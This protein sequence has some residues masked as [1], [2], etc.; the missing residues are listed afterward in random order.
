MDKLVSGGWVRHADGALELQVPRAQLLKQAAAQVLLTPLVAASVGFLLADGVDELGVLLAV[1]GLLAT[2]GVA[3]GALGIA[4]SGGVSAAS[5]VVLD[6][7]AGEVRHPEGRVATA[8]VR[9][10][11]VRQGSALTKWLVLEARLGPTA[12][13][14]AGPYAPP[15]TRS[16]VLLGKVPP[17]LGP[18]LAALARDLGAKLGIE[19]RAEGGVDRA[20]PLG[21]TPGTVAMLCYLPV[22]GIFLVASIGVLVVARDPILRFHARQS[23]VL[24]A[25]ELAVI[26]AAAVLGATAAVVSPELGV[27]VMGLLLLG[28]VMGRLVVRLIASFKASR[29]EPFVVPGL[30]PIVGRWLPAADVAT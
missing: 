1:T 21:M 27:V 24:F 15:S 30:R 14:V 5:R 12:P 26:V 18:D 28:A 22:Q 23:L 8:D 6:L 19:A 2:I 13:A 25:I 17:A 11:V 10:L 3:W 7:E 16:I 4:R 9:A 20:G 29:L